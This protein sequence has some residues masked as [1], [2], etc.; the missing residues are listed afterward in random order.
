MNRKI[1]LIIFLYFVTI[2]TQV[3]PSMIKQ[4][5]PQTATKFWSNPHLQKVIQSPAWSSMPYKVAEGVWGG[6]YK[7]KRTQAELEKARF[8][9]EQEGFRSWSYK[10][11]NDI[12]ELFKAPYRRLILVHESQEQRL[13]NF[14]RI[15]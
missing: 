4:M 10:Q 6:H 13:D 9:I 11:W 7:R 1:I 5:L 14:E 8:E 15:R 12:S 3:L 2:P